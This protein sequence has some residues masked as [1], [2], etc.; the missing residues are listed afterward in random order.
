MSNPMDTF[1]T[2]SPSVF[3][4]LPTTTPVLSPQKDN[5]ALPPTTILFFAWMGALP[6]HFS[7]FLTHYLTQY[8]NAR[9][10][11]VIS[12]KS[13]LLYRSN[14][15]LQQRLEPALQLILADVDLHSNSSNKNRLLAHAFSNGGAH[16][17]TNLLVA[18]HHQTGKPM[19]L[20]TLILD[21]APGRAEPISL[22]SALRMSMPKQTYIQLSMK[23]LLFI[24]LGALWLI[25]RIFR[26]ENAVD[27]LRRLL[28]DPHVS[29]LATKRSYVYSKQDQLVRWQDVES[30]AEEAEKRGYDVV[31]EEFG[32]SAHVSHMRMD[33]V[34]Y[35]SGVERVW[36]E[37][38][39]E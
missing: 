24:I 39:K 21:S 11:L 17:L 36:G 35:W 22:N 34:K 27:H 20:K 9:I 16:A 1:K 4:H 13:D 6:R 29:S 28:N 8:P 31:R 32:A 18:F 5:H 25:H 15:A 23:L 10:I 7:K 30:H 38:V 19:P 14:A 33:A 3:V 37:A 2:L 26:L 12:T